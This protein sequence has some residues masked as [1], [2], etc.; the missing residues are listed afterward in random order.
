[1]KR[2]ENVKESKHGPLVFVHTPRCAGNYVGQILKDLGIKNK[3]QNLLTRDEG[4]SFTVIRDP[5]E[6]MES[7]LDSRLNEPRPKYDWPTHL[8]SVYEDKSITINK[9]IKRMSDSELLDFHP[10]K[11]LKYWGKNI[12]IFITIDQ[13]EKFLN[14]FGYQFYIDKYPETNMSQKERGDFDEISKERIE[15]L[16][17]NDIQLYN[18]IKETG[19]VDNLRFW[20]S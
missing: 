16:Y 3:G 5:V 14:F 20:R 7:F 8:Y 17:Q 15:R 6:R 12:D 19:H 10:Y 2:W 1:M 11:T 18:D 13:L 9:I 4:I